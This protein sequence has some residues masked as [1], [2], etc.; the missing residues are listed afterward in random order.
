MPSTL[1][2]FDLL[3]YVLNLNFLS[4]TTTPNPLAQDLPKYVS[5]LLIEIQQEKDQFAQIP[6]LLFDIEYVKKKLSFMV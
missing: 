4:F 6:K 5:E 2:W 3:V 1:D